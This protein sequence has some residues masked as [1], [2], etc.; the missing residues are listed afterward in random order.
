MIK[1]AIFII[2]LL[3]VVGRETGW[4]QN[5]G[6]SVYFHKPSLSHDFTSQKSTGFNPKVSV[7]LGN[8]FS[9]FSPYH[10]AFC[11]YIMPQLTLP[12]NKKF[13]V[14]AG[15]GYSSVFTNFGTEGTVFTNKPQHYG[16][17]YVEGIY[18]ISN[19][20]T[21]SALGYKTFNLQAPTQNEKLNP[22]AMDMSNEGVYF[23]LNY[24]VNDKFEINAGFS[25]DNRNRSPYGYGMS[26]FGAPPIPGMVHGFSPMGGY[27]PF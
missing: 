7:S 11:T 19:H 17:V 8:S 14:R 20:V 26:P 6:D 18:Q 2:L 5:T 15:M 13:A 24:K 9:S 25:Y 4:A 22:H 1:K 3:T 10:Q 21:I 27:P 23:N 16:T 12:V